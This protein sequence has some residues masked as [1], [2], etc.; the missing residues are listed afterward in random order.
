[1]VHVVMN[2]A[3]G[4][5]CLGLFCQKK[6]SVSPRNLFNHPER[7]FQYCVMLWEWLLGWTIDLITQNVKVPLS[8]KRK[9]QNI[10]YKS[11]PSFHR[12]NKKNYSQ[13]SHACFLRKMGSCYF[14]LNFLHCFSTHAE[15]KLG[16]V[17]EIWAAAVK[18][19]A[20]RKELR[21]PA[22]WRQHTH[23]EKELLFFWI[24]IDGS[25]CAI[26]CMVHLLFPWAKP[27]NQSN[28][29]AKGGNKGA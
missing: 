24:I 8:T 4:R 22:A 23:L 25:S 3:E 21:D 11:V 2:N 26:V 17:T 20:G 7:G 27:T 28:P 29:S 18:K 12:L 6:L 19:E 16:T 5:S 10:I 1:M 15:V 13:H 14:K 9:D